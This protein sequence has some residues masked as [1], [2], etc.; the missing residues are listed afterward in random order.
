[1]N[2]KVKDA[3]NIEYILASIFWITCGLE[4]QLLGGHVSIKFRNIRFQTR[5]RRQTWIR[6]QSSIEQESLHSRYHGTAQICWNMN[7]RHFKTSSISARWIHVNLPICTN[8][9]SQFIDEPFFEWNRTLNLKSRWL[10][11][12][13]FIHIPKQQ[14]KMLANGIHI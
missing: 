6:Q 11:T 10:S 3:M 5:S 13:H 2:R 12:E 1:M 4:W 9:E 7:F 8:M 14:L